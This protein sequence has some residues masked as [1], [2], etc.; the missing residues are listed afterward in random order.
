MPMAMGFSRMKAYQIPNTIY[1]SCS[2][3]GPFPISQEIELVQGL[4]ACLDNYR[5]IESKRS[6][7]SYDID[8]VGL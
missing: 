2:P 3:A 6:Q 5:A 4:Q 1:C 7:L 8:G